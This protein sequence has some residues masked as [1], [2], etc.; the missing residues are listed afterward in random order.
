MTVANML[1][2]L[3][4]CPE[5]ADVV[6]SQGEE[7]GLSIVWEGGYTFIRMEVKPEP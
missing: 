6:L 3:Q 1:E 2:L 7:V 5:D 4:D